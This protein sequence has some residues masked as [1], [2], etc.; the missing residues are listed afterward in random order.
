MRDRIERRDDAFEPVKGLAYVG[1]SA[2]ETT[3]LDPRV[4]KLLGREGYAE[5]SEEQPGRGED[6]FDSHRA[7]AA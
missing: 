7:D 1:L 3:Y 2:R 6:F 5:Q 4:A